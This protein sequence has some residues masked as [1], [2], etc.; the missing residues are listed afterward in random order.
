MR[1]I[2]DLF[3]FLFVIFLLFVLLCF[4]PRSLVMRAVVLRT[5]GSGLW[6]EPVGVGDGG[7]LH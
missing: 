7:F 2:R 6:W 4:G 1:V 3:A 5:G